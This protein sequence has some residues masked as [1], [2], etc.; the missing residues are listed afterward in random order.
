MINISKTLNLIPGGVPVIVNVSQYDKG[1]TLNFAIY[2]QGTLF[3]IPTG[4]EVSIQGTKPDGHGF[5]YSCT[6]SGSTVTATLQQQMTAVA[7]DVL[8]EIAISKS[9]NL[10]AT[11]NFILRVEKAALGDD[12]VISD[13]EIP[14]IIALATQQVE[15]A[16]AWANGT[17]NGVPVG[18]SDPAYHNNSYYWSQQPKAAS[19]ITYDNTQSGLPSTNVQ[20]AVDDLK[21]T[22]S[23][24]VSAR[25]QLGAHNLLPLKLSD[26][27]E[28]NTSGTWTNNI[29][30]V[31]GLNITVGTDDNDNVTSIN[32]A[33]TASGTVL[34]FINNSFD[35]ASHV[36]ELL[37]GY[38]SGYTGSMSSLAYRFYKSDNT[39]E[40]NI[41]TND[42]AIQNIGICNFVIRVQSGYNTNN[43]TLYP[44]LRL[45]TD[46]DTTHTPYAETNQ[47][48]TQNKVDWDSNAFLGAHSLIANNA[49]SSTGDINFTVNSDKSVSLSGSSSSSAIKDMNTLTGAQIKALGESLIISGGDAKAYVA[50]RSA[51][52]SKIIRSY[53]DEV[54]FNT[55][56]LS[57]SVTY[58]Y[59]IGIAAN[60]NVDGVTVYPMVRNGNDASKK[61]TPFAMTNQQLTEMVSPFGFEVLNLSTTSIATLLASANINT[62]K[63]IAF[64]NAPTDAPSG[65]GNGF[66]M[67][68]LIKAAE[69]VGYARAIYMINGNYY[70]GQYDKTNN[71]ITW[72]KLT[73]E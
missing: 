3:T 59:T 40:F 29:L 50:I 5:A 65:T 45:A 39:A 72:S 68:L 58:Y 73:T 60:T 35:S 51:D 12:T 55:S 38:P 61:Y 25:S 9:G 15:D 34:F 6:F 37:N 48:L 56:E 44:M 33:G 28:L 7:G 31:N 18:S 41:L 70:I 53:G 36:S 24:E 13:T 42:E 57:D 47:Q 1:Q 30:T 32:F 16:E 62:F 21:Q 17:R 46:S 43:I 71:V 49:A 19:Q 10:I 63:V 54:K 66:G 22:L 23:D 27:K 11:A 69:D 64:Y 2:D 8:T 14:E 20:G 52:W 67:V 26:L 4:A